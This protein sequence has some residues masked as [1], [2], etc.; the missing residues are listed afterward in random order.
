[1]RP[2]R[3]LISRESS[4]RQAGIALMESLIA[5]L[6]LA[7]GV[8]GLAGV[9]IRLL[10]ESRVANHR[11]V[12]IGLIDD[13]ANRIMNNR[14]AAL[15]GA[16]TSAWGATSLAVN[17]VATPC[18][19]AQ[20]AQSDVFDWRSSVVAQ[21][22]GGNATVFTSTNDPRQFGIAVSWRANEG[23]RSDTD[24]TRYNRPFTLNMSTS[25]VDCPAGSIC[26]LIY[27]HP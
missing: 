17:C 23:G 20:L 18:S 10:A 5:L 12:A 6:V 3:I 25:G 7:L 16:Y 14:N 9:Q 26:H 4:S 8:M 27:V 1:M 2:P 21:L 22:P 15:A 24:V 13:M 11:A 19:T